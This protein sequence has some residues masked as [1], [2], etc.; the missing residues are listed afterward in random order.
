MPFANLALCILLC[1]P[2]NF[3]KGRTLI[4]ITHIPYRDIKYTYMSYCCII[5]DEYSVENSVHMKQG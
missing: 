3:L 4:I 5:K 1:Y 2:L